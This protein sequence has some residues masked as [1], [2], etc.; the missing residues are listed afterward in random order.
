[1]LFARRVRTARTSLG[2]TLLELVIALPIIALAISLSYKAYN[3]YQQTTAAQSYGSAL[4][5]V[6]NNV[7]AYTQTYWQQ[8]QNASSITLNDSTTI[9]NIY[10][11]TVA[12]LKKLVKNPLSS[13]F[14]TNNVMNASPVVALSLV[15]AGCG[16][17]PSTCNVQGLV[18]WN[19]AYVNANGNPNT[20][21]ASVAATQITTLG[22]EG[23]FSSYGT[24]GTIAG[25]DGSW[26]M[27]NP[28]NAAAVVGGFVSTAA[29]ANQIFVKIGDNRDPSLTGNLTVAG[30]LSSS[31]GNFTVGAAGNITSSSLY[32]STTIAAGTGFTANSSG[33]VTISNT[34]TLGTAAGAVTRGA[35]T[36][37][38]A[39]A[40]N[41]DGK[42]QILSCQNLIWLPV[43]G[44]WERMGYYTVNDYRIS[45]I[46]NPVPKPTCAAGGTPAITVAPVNFTVNANNNSNGTINYGAT[47]AGP[48]TVF[49]QDGTGT[50]I[51]GAVASVGVFCSF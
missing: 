8:L 42:G 30:N 3:Y 16:S 40:Q 10:A 46:N 15:P 4:V 12:E 39:M 43:G 47:G 48:W 51:S 33:Q 19:T 23:G 9:A 36:T 24:P 45:A 14:T 11:P 28:L 26:S 25:T 50:A 2:F 44:P 5:P 27:V 38:G 22:A 31:S 41:A 35:C 29:S 17:N 20:Y 49:I 7:Q 13:T 6:I 1:M 21:F 32:S 34:L 18:Y 37:N